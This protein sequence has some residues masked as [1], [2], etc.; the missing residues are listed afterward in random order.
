MCM[1]TFITSYKH[2]IIPCDLTHCI[3]IQWEYSEYGLMAIMHKDPI[4]GA[5]VMV[6]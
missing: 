5:I 1:H 3:V 6:V 4:V 2:P